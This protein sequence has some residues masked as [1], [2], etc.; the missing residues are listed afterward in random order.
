VGK[1]ALFALSPPGMVQ[2]GALRFANPTVFNDELPRTT[3]M[4]IARKA[5]RQRGQ[6]V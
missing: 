5:L 3:L 2:V 6:S 1:G 4:K